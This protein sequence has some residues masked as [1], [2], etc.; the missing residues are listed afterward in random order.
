MFSFLNARVILTHFFQK[1]NCFFEKVEKNLQIK[2]KGVAD[3][4]GEVYN[5]DEVKEM[6][7]VLCIAVALCLVMGIC[8][9]GYQSVSEEYPSSN[10]EMLA[11][12]CLIDDKNDKYINTVDALEVFLKIVDEER[13]DYWLSDWYSIDELEVLDETVDE[14]TK[15]LLMQLYN[16]PYFLTVEDILR[17]DYSA[18]ITEYD[19]LLFAVRLIGD[20]YFCVDSSAEYGYRTKEEVYGKAKEKG[21]IKSKNSRNAEKPISREKFYDIVSRAINTQFS[22]GGDGGPTKVKYADFLEKR[23]RKVDSEIVVTTTEIEIPFKWNDDFSVSA[24]MPLDLKNNDFDEDITA[25]TQSGKKIIAVAY[26]EKPDGIAV[27]AA[28][29]CEMAARAYP[30]KLKEIEICYY[31]YDFEVHTKEE[32]IFKLDT[33]N[34][35]IICQGNAPKVGVYTRNKGQWPVKTLSMAEGY[36]FK[37][38]YFYTIVC[39]E[40]KYRKDEYNDTGYATFGND[41]DRNTISDFGNRGSFG[42]RYLDEIRLIEIKATKTGSDTFKVIVTPISENTFAV[43]EQ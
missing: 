1:C 41:T 11:R 14:E 7:R 2:I 26:G 36:S 25:Y 40:H 28:Q 23:L 22:L 12:Y 34:I 18:D 30:E 8:I 33:S 3:V 9:W 5:Y 29:L 10:R 20:T 42:A 38:G 43:I 21:L 37:A 6:K 4:L 35:D 16:E 39:K 13:K 17:L 31:K 15:K 24:E 27:T 19:A 32:Y